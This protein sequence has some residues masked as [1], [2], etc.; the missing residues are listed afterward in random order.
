MDLEPV[1][2]SVSVPRAALNE[3]ETNLLLISF[4]ATLY[5]IHI[6]FDYPRDSFHLAL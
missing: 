1:S 3:L 2:L 6:A 5:T 4:Q